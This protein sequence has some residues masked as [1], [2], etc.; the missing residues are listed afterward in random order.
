LDCTDKAAVCVLC[1]RN[2]HKFNILHRIEK[3]NGRFYQQGA[4]WQVG[5]KIYIGH[6]GNPCPKSNAALSDLSDQMIG[7]IQPN[8]PVNNLSEVAKQF[9]KTEEEV[10]QI[11]SDSLEANMTSMTRIQND[12]LAS[13]AE[14]AGVG[15]LGLLEFLRVALSNKA[16]EDSED[17]QTKSDRTTAEVERMEDD[18]V[19]GSQVIID[20]LED[21]IGGD[22]DWEDED[23]RPAKGELPRFSP[24]P[25]P[26][27]GAGNTFIT[28]VHTNG[29]HSLP[30]VWCACSDHL[31]DRD[32]QLLDLHMYPA[33]Y[34][35]IRTV[36]TFA[37]LDEHRCEYLECKS[38]HYQHHNK[39]RRLTFPAYP[40]LSPNRY[41]ELCRVARQWRNLKYRKWFWVLNNLNVKRGGMALFCAACPQ[42]GVNLE[43]DWEAEQENHPWVNLASEIKLLTVPKGIYI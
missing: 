24:R 40:D 41:T 9:Q 8:K 43:A 4:L 25:P 36:F 15:V 38:S 3:W 31:E 42:P 14:K 39:L 32:L 35:Q 17:L 34:D 26:V 27:D 18:H 21:E 1:C 29:F 20:L 22:D 28:V 19:A 12:V 16:E 33:S 7:E 37:C 5:V 30:V 23:E 6:N 10:L 2:S 13:L 11:V